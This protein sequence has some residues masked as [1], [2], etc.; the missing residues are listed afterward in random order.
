MAREGK[1]AS[2]STHLRAYLALEPG[3]AEADEARQMLEKTQAPEP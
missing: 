3:S 2:A 1:M